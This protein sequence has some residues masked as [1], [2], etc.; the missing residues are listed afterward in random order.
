MLETVAVSGLWKRAFTTSRV[1]VPMHGYYEWTGTRGAKDAH[2]LHGPDPLLMA[3]GICTA[4]RGNDSWVVTFSVITREAC[5]AAGETH[6]RMPAFLTPDV[7]DPWLSPVPLDTAAKTADMLDLLRAASDYVAPTVSSYLVD[8]KVNNS[9]TV[10]RYD[11]S[12]IE[13]TDP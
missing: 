13:P 7:F 9:H 4:R 8:R 11:P 6:D 3:A 1:L 5:D 12:L 2:F 10:P